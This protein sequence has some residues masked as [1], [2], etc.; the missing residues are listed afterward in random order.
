MGEDG[1]EERVAEKEMVEEEIGGRLGE[2]TLWEDIVSVNRLSGGLNSGKA[3]TL[4][5]K[6]VR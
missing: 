4:V 1:V 5:F 6:P 2:K 3:E